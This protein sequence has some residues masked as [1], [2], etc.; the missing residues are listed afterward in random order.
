MRL[1]DAFCGAGG[2]AF[3]YMQAGFHVT[4][5]DIQPQPR[6]CGDTF[7]QGDALEYIAA[8]GHEYD[9]IHASPPCQGYSRTYAIHQHEHRAYPK[10]VPQVRATLQA[11]GRP[12]IIENTPGAPLHT[13]VVLCGGMFGLTVYRH[14]LFETSFLVWQPEDPP[15]PERAAAVGRP[16]PAHGYMTVAGHFSDVRAARKAM[17]IDWMTRDELSQAIPPAY[18]K[19]LGGH[20]RRVL[21][22]PEVP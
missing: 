8:H 15:H 2:S 3:G 5:V 21:T 20:L 10:L 14:R 18:T 9:A 11:T 6:Y 19:W 12:Y 4:G 22:A 1:L 13:T 17:G 16:V 7:V